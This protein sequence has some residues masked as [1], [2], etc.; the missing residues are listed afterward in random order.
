MNKK[1][2]ALKIKMIIMD[3][4]DTRTDGNLLLFLDGEV[5]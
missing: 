3:V 4:D 1:E 2:R 5:L